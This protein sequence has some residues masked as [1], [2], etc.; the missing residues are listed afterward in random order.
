MCIVSYGDQLDGD[1]V[2]DD[3]AAIVNNKQVSL[4]TDVTWASIC[5]H[6]YWGTPILSPTSH[7][8]WRPLTTLSFR[9]EFQHHG[10]SSSP[11]WMKLTNLILHILISCYVLEFGNLFIK[12][13]CRTSFL[14]AMLF[15][16]H[17]IH[18]EAVSGI[19]GRADLLATLISTLAIG[20]YFKAFIG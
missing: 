1:F 11:H 3:S 13:H 16:V 7:K 10:K 9:I 17:P 8:S 2:F 20:I 19:V 18:V 5:S 4:G 15:S 12:D 14:A 6:D